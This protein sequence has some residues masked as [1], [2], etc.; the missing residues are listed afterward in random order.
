MKNGA[1]V[2]LLCKCNIRYPSAILNFLLQV[3]E[4]PYI[5]WILFFT[6][7]TIIVSYTLYVYIER[8]YSINVFRI[9]RFKFDFRL[10]KKLN[11]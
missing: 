4:G 6:L 5:P 11:I 1:L 3:F 7:G 8:E 9:K 2:F 10:K